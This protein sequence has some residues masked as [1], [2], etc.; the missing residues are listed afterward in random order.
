MIQMWTMKHFQEM[1]GVELPPL[2]YAYTALEPLIGILIV[3]LIAFL[4]LGQI[5]LGS[6]LT[7]E[8]KKDYIFSYPVPTLSVSGELDGLA[9]VTRF[10]E[11]FYTQLM[12]SSSPYQSD[13]KSFP[14]TVVSGATH[15][16]FASGQPPKLVIERDLIPEISSEEAHAKIAY[17]VVNFMKVRLTSDPIAVRN[18]NDRVMK[19]QSFLM[20]IINALQLE[21]YHNFRPPC[22]CKTDNCE[23]QANC[24]AACPFTNS[25]SQPTMGSGLDG[26]TISDLDSFHD[27]WETEPEVHLPTITNSCSSPEGCTLT[28]QTITQGVC[29]YCVP[30]PFLTLFSCIILKCR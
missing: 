4:M 25:I 23:P 3:R 7:R 2:P 19:S 16:Q 22:L 20:P 17:D 30:V 9:R 28:M 14:V 27:V 10:A 15:M 26:L 24:T 18:L 5:L 13:Y 6:F 8:W 1:L 11:A 29:K 21:G 12:D